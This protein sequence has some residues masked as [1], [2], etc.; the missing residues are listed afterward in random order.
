MMG[1][2][3]GMSRSLGSGRVSRAGA[4]ILCLTLI[5]GWW[6]IV[7]GQSGRVVVPSP[8]LGADDLPAADQAFY[9]VVEPRLRALATETLALVELGRS[10]SRDAGALFEGQ[11]RVQLLI[12]DI[13][14]FRDERGVPAR[15][16]PADE[17]YVAGRED[18]AGSIR[19]ARA[20][21]V[22]FDWE[23]LG[24]SV[25]QLDRAAGA[26]QTASRAMVAAAATRAIEAGRATGSLDWWSF[27]RQEPPSDSRPVNGQVLVA[28][29]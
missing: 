15:F 23:A 2:G 14:T 20:A 25:D 3:G 27:R 18:A 10:R 9:D 28:V 7:A 24:A 13:N 4:I 16:A 26:F 17:T 1:H 5:L 19:Q 6:A 29:L 22:R 21:L 11:R 12:R 8:A